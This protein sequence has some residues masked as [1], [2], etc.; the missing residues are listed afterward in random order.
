MD[1]PVSLTPMNIHTLTVRNRFVLPG[2]VTDMAV[3][4]GYVTE[5]LLSYYEER[6][7]GGVGLV[8]VEATSIDVSG[9]TFLHGLDISDDRFI[10]GLRLLTERVHAHGAAVAIQL[11][12]GGGRAHPEYSHMPRRVMSVI[13][14]VFEP[15]NAITLDGAEFARLADAWGKAALRAKAAGFDAVEIHGA[16]GYLLEQAVSAFTNRRTDGY[17]GSLAKRLRFPTEVARAVRAAVGEDFPILYRHTSVEDVPTGNGI[18]LHTTVELCRAL[19]DAGVNAFDITAGMQCCFELMTPPTCM[20][21]A[22]NAA[23]SAAVKQAIGDR[24]RVMLTG[25]ISDADTA[26]R[27]VRDGLADF[28]IMGRALIADSHLVEKYAA[29]RKDEICPCVACGQGCVGNADKMIPIT[30]ALNPL[31]GREASMPAV[32]KAETPR[33]VAVVGAGPAGL[34]AAATAAERGHEV[35]LLERSDR[36][37]GQINLAAVPPHKDDLRLI[38]DYLYRKAQRAG[39]AFRFSCEATPE[40]VRELSPDAVI[41]ATGSLPVIPHFCAS[42]AGAVTAQDILSGAEAGK[43]VLV[44]GGGLI[45]CE[46]AEYLAAQ[47]RSV[48]VVEMLP[49]LAKD[50][51]WC[52]RVLLLRRMASLGINLRPGNEILSIGADNAVTVRNGKGREETLSGFDTLVVAVGCRPDNALFNELSAAL[53]CPCA[54]VGDC[55]KTAKIMDAVHGGFEAALTL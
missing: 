6:A 16:S 28:A 14:G 2:M 35:I 45:G 34:M 22:W 5:R 32:P 30:C 48:T 47:G 37:G 44:L 12:H 4:G 38:S 23:T 46:T 42:A 8:I 17:G 29:G 49:Q 39:V 15:D 24:A 50:M 55:R 33:R 27:V 1:I 19:T 18:D 3:D 52:A 11:Q 26:E 51:E 21:K 13:P 9:K 31:S 25:R 10:P 7:K 43:N 20:P 40:S 53:D 41:V 36:H 54:A